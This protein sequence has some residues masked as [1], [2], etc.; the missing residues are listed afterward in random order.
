MPSEGKTTIISNLGIALAE[1]SRRVIIV[2]AD[3]RRPRQHQIF[4]VANAWGL[5]DLLQEETQIEDYPKETLAR[6]TDI[7]NLNLLV[8]GPVTLGIPS[9]LHSDRMTRLL[10]RLKREFDFVLIDCP[11]MIHLADARVVGRLADGVILVIRSGRTSQE[12][13]I[14]AVQ[15][16]N[17]DGTRVLGTI[18]NDWNP[19]DAVDGSAYRYNHSYYY[20]SK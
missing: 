9:I 15:R 17:E 18:L 6:K 13:A 19:K 10:G 3:M 20:T 1:M 11:P 8:S 5:S 14:S 12:A 16:F 2:D 4:D 7:P